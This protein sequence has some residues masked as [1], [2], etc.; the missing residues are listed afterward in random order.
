VKVRYWL[1]G[2][3]VAVGVINGAMGSRFAANAADMHEWS[4]FPIAEFILAVPSLLGMS[5][6]VLFLLRKY[7]PLIG[8]P[9]FG[10]GCYGL[11]YG[12]SELAF[13][14]LNQKPLL[15]S[16][17]LFVLGVELVFTILLARRLWW[18][19]YVVA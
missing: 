17:A 2:V 1:I 4:E 7:A 12:L 13:H 11:S 15:S 3:I 6:L 19:R 18:R 9:F 16:L 14:V 8:Y 5:W 10:L